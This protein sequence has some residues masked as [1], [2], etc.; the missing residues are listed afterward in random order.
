[1]CEDAGLQK[2]TN[3]C[4]RPTAATALFEVNVSEK[5]IQERT[6]HRSWVALRQYEQSTTLQHRVTTK[7]LV[8]NTGMDYQVSV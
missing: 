7:I 8:T 3:H 6:G 2:K 1:M 4:R 5:I